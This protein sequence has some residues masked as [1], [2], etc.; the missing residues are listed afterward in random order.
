[1]SKLTLKIYSKSLKKRKTIKCYYCDFCPRSTKLR[2]LE[3]EMRTH[4]EE[5]HKQV[6]EGLDPEIF[7]DEF[8]QEFIEFFID[9]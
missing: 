6:I 4:I 3:D 5:N 8:H 1:M 9:E 7:D 2:N